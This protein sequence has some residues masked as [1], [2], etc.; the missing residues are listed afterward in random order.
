MPEILNREVID[1]VLGV[2]NANAFAMARKVAKLE[3]LP[4]GISSGAALSARVRARPAR[5]NMPASASW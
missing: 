5:R 3:G 2:S 4:V 1:E